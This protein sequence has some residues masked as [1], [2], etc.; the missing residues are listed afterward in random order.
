MAVARSAAEY[1]E[2]VRLI[3]MARSQRR[4]ADRPAENQ[5]MN[6]A[7]YLRP[8]Q[9]KSNDKGEDYLI[10]SLALHEF[11]DTKGADEDGLL[12]P[13]PDVRALIH[14]AEGEVAARLRDTLAQL[15][16]ADMVLLVRR[17]IS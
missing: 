6:I 13:A 5:K 3:V 1:L 15:D 16:D 17:P 14:S 2:G 10:S 8:A 12:V 4:V 11:M 9:G 7:I